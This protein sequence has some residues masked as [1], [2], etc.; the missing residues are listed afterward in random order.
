[1]YYRLSYQPKYTKCSTVTIMSDENY[2][3]IVK[4][5]NLVYVSS[6]CFKKSKLNI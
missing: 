6:F 5:A 4:F 1:M 2:I 3:V